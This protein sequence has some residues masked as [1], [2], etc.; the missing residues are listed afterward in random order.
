MQSDPLISVVTA[1][2]NGSAFL[3]SSVRSALENHSRTEIIIVDDGSTDDSL[4][5]AASLAKQFPG[6]ILVISQSN[7]GPAGARNTGIRVA[8]GKYLGFLDVD[9]QFAPG[10]LDAAIDVLE[11]DP[12]AV[13]VSCRIELLDAH[14]PVADWQLEAMENSGPCNLLMRTETVR[15]IGGFPVDPAFRGEAGGEDQCFRRALLQFGSVPKIDRPFF[16][17]RMRPGKYVDLFLNRVSMVDGKIHVNY[18]TQEELNGSMQAASL[19]YQKD[20]TAR[21]L[22]RMVEKLKDV[23]A[24]VG[25]Y[26]QF[27]TGL[28]AVDGDLSAA[29]CHCLHWL[30]R[31]WPIDGGLVHIGGDPRSLYAMASAPRGPVTAMAPTNAPGIVDAPTR[32][33]VAN[34]VVRRMEHPDEVAATW[35]GRV[36]LLYIS[37]AGDIEQMLE[38]WTPRVTPFGLL[39]VRAPPDQPIASALRA[40]SNPWAEVLRLQNLVLFQK[41]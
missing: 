10:F 22:A 38:A 14:R 32:A 30:A 9:D 13:A 3:E 18:R 27:T 7:Q 1:C 24:A 26:G 39:V 33:G 40:A 41:S 36:R 12:R 11:R 2:Y 37:V 31:N 20:V 21:A 17:Y 16:R 8:R 15:V 5:H 28:A 23:S 6:R 19:R 4:A 35:Q 34:A 25:E 29:E